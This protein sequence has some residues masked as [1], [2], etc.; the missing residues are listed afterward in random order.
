MNFYIIFV[1]SLRAR[2]RRLDF[3]DDPDPCS[4]FHFSI[5]K[6]EVWPPG[7]AD[8][9]CPAG[10]YRH[11][12][13]IGPSAID[14]WL[15]R[16]WR[17]W[18]MRWSSSIRIQT[19]KFVGLAVRRYVA[20]CVWALINGPGGLEHWPFDL[21]TGTRVASKVGNLPSKFRHVRPYWVLKYSLCTRRTDGRTKAMLNCPF[22]TSGGIIKHANSRVYSQGGVTILP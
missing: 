16:S 1:K 17:L 8:T 4:L 10:L 9:V 7:S 13:S 20:R 3:G 11:R 22:P 5:A 12:Y 14:L 15:W 19:L 18:L 6:Q 2:N 21:E